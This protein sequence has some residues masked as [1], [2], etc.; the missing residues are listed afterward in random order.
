[1]TRSFDVFDRDDF[2]TPDFG[3]ARGIGSASTSF[4][5]KWRELQNIHREEERSDALAREA[6]QRSGRERPPVPRESVFGRS[7]SNAHDPR[8]QIGTG[9]TRSGIPRFTPCRKS[10]NSVLS[11]RTT[12]PNSRTTA[13]E[14]AWKTMLEAW[15]A[16]DSRR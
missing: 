2:R 7:W 9:R 1:M 4:W 13:T 11:P 6:Q 12:W 15:Y 5:D 16:K 10:A 3:S 14:T 8:L